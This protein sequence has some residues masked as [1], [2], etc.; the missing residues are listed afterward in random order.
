MKTLPYSSVGQSLISQTLKKRKTISA[1]TLDKF[2]QKDFAAIAEHPDTTP[3]EKI[4]ARMSARLSTSYRV[5]H[6]AASARWAAA[7]AITAATGGGTGYLI[8]RIV[9]DSWDKYATLYYGTA[10][11]SLAEC[12]LKTVIENS[13]AGS[14][15]RELAEAALKSTE[16]STIKEGDRAQLRY[17]ALQEIGKLSKPGFLSWFGG[18][19]AVAARPSTPGSQRPPATDPLD[20]LVPKLPQHLQSRVAEVTK[21]ANSLLQAEGLLP[22]G[23][24]D[25]YH[26]QQIASGFM[27]SA[28]RGYLDA[29]A[30]SPEE[31]FRQKIEHDLDTQLDLMRHQ[32]DTFETRYRQEAADRMAEHTQFLTESFGTSMR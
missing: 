19:A 3:R 20:K 27:A 32:L 22:A 16:D 14:A 23:S 10:A 26:T 2:L 30:G 7:N 12:G 18:N 29:T 25:L 21:R 13:E 6:Y 24:R 11:A 17:D 8:A 4:I 5:E 1:E 9:H 31:G 28:V 15:E